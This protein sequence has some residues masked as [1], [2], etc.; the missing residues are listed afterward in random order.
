MC[1]Q[2][3]GGDDMPRIRNGPEAYR[4]PRPKTEVRHRPAR[5]RRLVI[6]RVDVQRQVVPDPAGTATVTVT[7]KG[8]LRGHQVGHLQHHQEGP[9]RRRGRALQGLLRL[10]RRPPQARGDGRHARRKGARRGNRLRGLLQGQ[11]GRRHCDRSRHG[12]RQLQGR[13]HEGLQHHQE[14]P[15]RRHRGALQDVLR[16]H[17]HPDPCRAPSS[18]DTP[19]SAPAR[20]G[21]SDVARAPRRD[22]PRRG[23][24]CRPS[25]PQ[26]VSASVPLTRPPDTP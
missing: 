2:I 20:A 15:L 12:H 3:L 19:L 5:G 22:R 8:G 24:P 10:R 6:C 13:G 26:C 16:L 11:P 1:G 17:R 25:P 7:G 14:G 21:A 23:A 4:T 18:R 9:L